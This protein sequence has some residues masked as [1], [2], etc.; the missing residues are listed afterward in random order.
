M[1]RD[2]KLRLKII[3]TLINNNYTNS[4]EKNV[5]WLWIDS[6]RG[7][8]KIVFNDGKGAY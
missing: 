8:V 7:K 6:H 5:W 3:W 4:D 1:F 2:I